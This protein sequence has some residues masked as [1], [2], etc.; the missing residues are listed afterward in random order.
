MVYDLNEPDDPPRLIGRFA[1]SRCHKMFGAAVG[2]SGH[3]YFGGRWM[4][5]G[6]GGGLGWWDPIAGTEDGIWESFS[7]QQ[8]EYVTPAGGGRF[9]VLSTL[10]VNDTVLRKPTLRERKLVVFDDAAKKIVREITVAERVPGSGPIASA[11]GTRVIGWTTNP[12][13]P[14]T[15]LLYGADV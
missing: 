3:L 14:Q 9:I 5:N 4:R 1:K 15:S 8:I 13:K 10:R 12:A 2:A 11:G 6:N 7:N